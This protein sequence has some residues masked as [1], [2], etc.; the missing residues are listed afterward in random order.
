MPILL[1]VGWTGKM[2]ISLSSPFAPENFLA[3]R[4]RPFRPASARS[5]STLKLN[6][7]SSIINHQSSII[8]HQSGA[9]SDS[10]RFPRRCPFICTAI[11]YRV[12]PKFIGS[13]NCVSTA[14]TT[15]I[16]PAQGPLVLEVVPVTNGCYLWSYH[17]G[18]INVRLS[19]LVP[20]IGMKWAC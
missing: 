15:K 14:F 1:V 5:F 3:R 8:N 20:T 17:H 2:D 9:Y 19:F 4:V 13:R 11:R 10:S 16:S 18:P 12:S 7:Q 6:H